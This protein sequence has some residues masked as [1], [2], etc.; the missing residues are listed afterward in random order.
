MIWAR[1][2][3]GVFNSMVLARSRSEYR[4]G[5]PTLS[6]SS[7]PAV[8][9]WVGGGEGGGARPC[10]I[11]SGLGDGVFKGMCSAFMESFYIGDHAMLLSMIYGICG[12]H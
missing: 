8:G 5:V 10:I 7:V 12:F 1:G 4:R 6:S 9:R 2:A 3:R 11:K